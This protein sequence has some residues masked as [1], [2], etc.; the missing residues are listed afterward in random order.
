VRLNIVR[1]PKQ[2]L[3]K[4]A[5]I[6]E[7]ILHGPFKGLSKD[8]SAIEVATVIQEQLNILESMPPNEQRS[9]GK[10]LIRN[11]LGSIGVLDS[12]GNGLRDFENS[13]TLYSEVIKADETMC[14][15]SDLTD[16]SSLMLYASYCDDAF[17]LH[18]ADQIFLKAYDV[19]TRK[20]SH[21][22]TSRMSPAA[23]VPF[24][25]KAARLGI[26]IE[27]AAGPPTDICPSVYRSH[28]KH[29]I[30]DG[31]EQINEDMYSRIDN[32]LMVF[33]GAG[34]EAWSGK[35]PITKISDPLDILRRTV[36]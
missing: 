31:F 29:E 32:K 17:K 4:S 22:S 16:P 36:T 25:K 2:K 14:E 9:T 5:H 30:P 3:A 23:P 33:N 12:I 19:S 27:P 20:S 34:V 13:Q 8:E 28:P 11:G 18:T 35:L 26:F 15:R 1:C 7:K 24:V 6:G 21:M 10:D